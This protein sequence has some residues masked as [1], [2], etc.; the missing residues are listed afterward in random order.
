MRKRSVPADQAKPL[1]DK[2]GIMLYRASK[3]DCDACVL[4]PRCCP[5]TPAA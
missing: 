3:L 5:N 1:V 2:D 4:K